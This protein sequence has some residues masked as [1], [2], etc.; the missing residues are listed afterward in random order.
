M[1]SSCALWTAVLTV[2]SKQTG[3]FCYILWMSLISCCRKCEW[4][5]CRVFGKIWELINHINKYSPHS[6]LSPGVQHHVPHKRWDTLWIT[7]AEVLVPVQCSP[8]RK[9]TDLF[10]DKCHHPAS[11]NSSPF[12]TWQTDTHRTQ[13]PFQIWEGNNFRGLLK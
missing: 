5:W 10:L 12:V 1:K 13:F 11:L 9:S 2:T 3:P 6:S 7:T 8:L 4:R